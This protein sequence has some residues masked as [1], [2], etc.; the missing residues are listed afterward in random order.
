MRV[1]LRAV[2]YLLW[3]MAM[4]GSAVGFDHRDVEKAQSDQEMP[5]LTIEQVQAKYQGSGAIT[6]DGR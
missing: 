3:G 6:L 5:K 2:V 1:R 4:T